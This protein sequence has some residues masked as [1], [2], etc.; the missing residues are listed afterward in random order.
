[1]DPGELQQGIAARLP[2]LQA[3]FPSP[4]DTRTWLAGCAR[5][6]VDSDVPAF[7]L[8]LD[9]GG[10]RDFL[11]SRGRTSR[12]RLDHLTDLLLQRLVRHA[13]PDLVGSLAGLMATPRYRSIERSFYIVPV[14][15]EACR[16][17]DHFTLE[18]AAT[19]PD[20]AE[21]W[22]ELCASAE[23]AILR[24]AVNPA[25]LAEHMERLAGL[26]LGKRRSQPVL[27]A[28]DLLAS[29]LCL[30]FLEEATAADLRLDWY[31]AIF[32]IF[33]NHPD[34][35][36]FQRVLE[37]LGRRY[38]NGSGGAKIK[39]A[40]ALW[41]LMAHLE[42]KDQ[43]RLFKDFLQLY[44]NLKD[45]FSRWLWQLALDRPP[46]DSLKA[47]ALFVSSPFQS[48]VAGFRHKADILK[49]LVGN[50]FT[51]LMETEIRSLRLDVY[52]IILK[53]LLKLKVEEAFLDR[54]AALMA[55]IRQ[56]TGSE[57]IEAELVRI[58]LFE[59][60]FIATGIIPVKRP[61]SITKTISAEHLV[62][63]RQLD[64][65]WAEEGPKTDP[66][67]CFG[68]VLGAIRA[69]VWQETETRWAGQAYRLEEIKSACLSLDAE[70]QA[71]AGLAGL[72]DTEF[73]PWYLNFMD[74]YRR[75]PESSRLA[76]QSEHWCRVTFDDALPSVQSALLPIVGSL[77][78]WPDT[79]HPEPGLAYTEGTGI[80]LMQWVSNF[81]D[82]KEPLEGNRNLAFYVGLA[83][84]EAGHIIGGTF[85]VDQSLFI[86]KLERPGLYQYIHNVLEDWRVEAF[87]VLRKVHPLA[88]ELL[89]SINAWLTVR[90]FLAS[91]DSPP[92]IHD[93]LAWL[94]DEAS[95]CN[96]AI[97]DDPRYQARLAALFDQDLPCGRFPDLRA[98]ADYALNR[99]RHL[100]ILN[101]VLTHLLC[102]E[103]YEILRYWPE[104][105]GLTPPGV[106]NPKGPNGTGPAW[107]PKVQPLSP[108][109]LKGLYDEY[110]RNPVKFLGDLGLQALREEAEVRQALEDAGLAPARTA[111]PGK[112]ARRN[113]SGPGGP[114]AA[115]DPDNPAPDTPESGPESGGGPAIQGIGPPSGQRQA[116]NPEEWYRESGTI[117]ASTRTKVDDLMA[118][119][120]TATRQQAKATDPDETAESPAGQGL[121]DFIAS[122]GGQ[123]RRSR[124]PASRSAGQSGSRGKITRIYSL[125]PKTRSRTV[126][127]E[128]ETFLVHQVDQAWLK[129][130]GRWQPLA[131]QVANLMSQL[132]P[133][134][135]E[136]A[137]ESMLE[138]DI[139][140]DRL[141]GILASPNPVGPQAF[142]EDWHEQA[143]SRDLEVII[144]LDTSGSTAS[145]LPGGFTVLDIEKAFAIIFGGA[146]AQ[147]TGHI[148]Y[149][150]FNSATSTNVYEARSLACI[151]AFSADQ[152]NR[153]GDFIRYCTQRLKGSAMRHRYF[154]LITDGMPSSVNYDGKEALDDTLLAMREC[155]AAGIKLIY[156]NIDQ[157]EREYFAA[158]R[159]EATWAEH[160]ASPADLLPRIPDLVRTMVRSTD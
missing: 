70:D 104:A 103:L 87:L 86:A 115:A 139:D 60:I 51:V 147:L 22:L 93:L 13:R 20:Q 121:L 28:M 80:W 77:P 159:A 156:F 3:C 30:R 8:L 33:Q 16:L 2:D 148:H 107:T 52:G 91:L 108:E 101:P 137:E 36:E 117:D 88:K 6:L 11:A 120:Q 61:L 38:P 35:Q 126:L 49:L 50:I 100:D 56:Q 39:E 155:R 79:T 53:L 144:G 40:L 130:F 114:P 64:E 133:R 76:L 124:T 95:G 57:R 141:I 143:S 123:R 19:N 83:L 37:I 58:F 111:R 24:R 59:Y 136:A 29:P 150:A 71:I 97:R 153:D 1:M 113:P 92:G 98:M 127:T 151:S 63:V 99:L 132:L 47:L 18:V 158:F 81:R 78:V 140:L 48:M 116:F 23:F 105:M 85:A 119:A 142:L 25:Q 135:R 102:L 106:A 152:A 34:P 129:R 46:A 112:T 31:Q 27:Q 43:R 65:V 138:G 55:W 110:N 69:L 66:A 10:F 72:E 109:E 44:G 21:A 125:N 131:D 41:P 14:D 5:R 9:Q 54:R 45:D 32:G 122:G 74:L 134:T 73:D 82:P 154:F 128:V 42:G 68:P 89:G 12:K 146:L 160:Y 96:T 26:L 67:A 157:A 62:L 7:T 17:F 149:L 90:N 118:L 75:D 15:E 4:L 84:H 94:F 145:T